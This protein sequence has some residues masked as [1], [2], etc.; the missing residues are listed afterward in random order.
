MV[1]C[2]RRI[3]CL[4]CY[5]SFCLALV[6]A[7]GWAAR[8]R[9]L[10]PVH[11]AVVGHFALTGDRFAAGQRRGIDIAAPPGTEVRAACAGRV[12]FAGVV[13]DAGRTV[14]VRCGAFNA[15]YLHLG[16]VAVHRGSELGA[17]DPLGVVG[18]EGRLRLGARVRAHRFGYVDP[19]K[20]LVRD[21]PGPPPAL[22]PRGPAEPYAGV[23]RAAFPASVPV[24]ARPVAARAPAG[25]PLGGLWVPAGFGLLIALAGLTAVGRLR[26]VGPERGRQAR[27]SR[28]GLPGWS[29]PAERRVA[30]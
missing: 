18:A 12:S 10:W 25:L 22:A 28:G 24:R 3:A 4:C 30:N 23:P 17:A 27:S 6:P 13:P 20:L 8:P 29:S 9:W 26:V 11:G 14:T 7:D 21:P 5:L 2:M 15:T 1:H 16:S 19:L